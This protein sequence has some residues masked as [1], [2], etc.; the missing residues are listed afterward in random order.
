ML[1]SGP[2]HHMAHAE[3][4]YAGL[5]PVCRLTIL[6]CRM[7]ANSTVLI[8]YPHHHMASVTEQA[9]LSLIYTIATVFGVVAN[10]L[11]IYATKDYH[12]KRFLSQSCNKNKKVV[13]AAR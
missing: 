5:S 3:P 12:T 2:H 9:L 13:P 10:S 11:V 1:L 4:I 8:E 7:A 6:T